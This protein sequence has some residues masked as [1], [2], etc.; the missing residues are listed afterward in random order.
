MES[1][2]K[3]CLYRYLYC[4]LSSCAWRSRRYQDFYARLHNIMLPIRPMQEE[5]YFLIILVDACHLDYSDGRQFFQS[6]AV[7]PTN[8]SKEE[9]SDMLGSICKA[10]AMIRIFV[11]EGGHSGEREEPPVRYFD[12]IMNYNDCGYANPTERANAF[13]LAMNL[14]RSNIYG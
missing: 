10:S 4:L 6:V 9:M 8:G 13:I 2:F 1:Y 14:I 5:D 3:A 12:G 11:L 7:H